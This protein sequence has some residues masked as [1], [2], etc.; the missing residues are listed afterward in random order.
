MHSLIIF[1]SGAGS[2]ARAIIDYFKQSGQAHVCL[3][4]CNKEGTGVLNIAAAE[5]I[6]TLL[7]DKTSIQEN[8]FV[9]ALKSYNPSLIVLAG[10]LW[11]VP[12]NVINAFSA[13]IINIHPALLPKFGGKGMYGMNVHN[14][15]V[16]S[17]DKDSGITIHYVNEV[18]DSGNII[19]QARCMVE[20]NDTGT[21]LANKI[22][23]LEHFF[24]PRSIEYLLNEINKD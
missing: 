11:K 17:G 24:F 23:R 6:P 16:A 5:G 21:S 3:I 18:Y 8:D 9:D 22:H 19:M 7:I 10:F 20:S 4:V 13:K 1:A 2:N 12:D 14:A 15:V